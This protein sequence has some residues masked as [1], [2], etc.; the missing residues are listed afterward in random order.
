MIQVLIR[1]KSRLLIG[2]PGWLATKLLTLQQRREVAYQV[3]YGSTRSGLKRR[4]YGWREQALAHMMQEGWGLGGRKTWAEL[5]S[6]V[7]P[8]SGR[9]VLSEQ[10]SSLST[11]RLLLLKS[12][13]RTGVLDES[14]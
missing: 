1:L 11:S 10:G 13:Q 8:I 4:G 7:A 6:H 3:A 12:I 2:L 9:P 5:F 14:H